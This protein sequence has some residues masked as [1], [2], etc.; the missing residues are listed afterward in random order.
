MFIVANWKAY[1]EDSARAAHLFT[2]SKKLSSVTE[3]TIV[4]A[5]PAPFMGILARTNKSKVAF[6]A[7]DMSATNG[8]AATGETTAQMYASIGASFAIVG[9]SERRA[10]GDTNHTITE[11]LS[12][13][14][15]CGLT[16]ILCI[17]ER[18][19]DHEGQYLAF[20]REEITAAY[21]A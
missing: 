1:I 14:L 6:A 12:H 10:A 17:G 9:H 11:K 20:I 5:P 15:A 8:G 18:E 2:T 7:Q 16:P 3:H 13:A 4:L 21:T 19:R